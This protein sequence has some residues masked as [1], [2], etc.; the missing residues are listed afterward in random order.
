MITGIVVALPEELSTLTSADVDK[1]RCYPLS[2]NV[3]VAL[4]G[5]GPDNARKAAQHLLTQGATRLISWGCA[6]ALAPAAEPGD[7]TLPE[8]VLQEGAPTYACDAG[9]RNH[10]QS[11][12]Q[13]VVTIRTGALAGSADI[14]ANGADKLALHSR[15]DA[16]AL[17]MESHAVIS[18]SAE[19]GLPGLV[20]RAIADP[21][22]MNLPDAVTQ[23]LTPD[24]DVE[25]G[26]LLRHLLRHPGQ[27]PG[28]I[29]LGLHFKAAQKTLRS[30]AVNLDK[31]TEFSH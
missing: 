9:W 27:I 18:V 24:G 30:A 17:D 14:V 6:A 26:V 10:C 8:T 12:L 28:L 22:T 19:A 31:I 13:D 23:A 15:T 21:A 4:A 20:I 25:L 3:L 7:L 5:A 16:V 11:I 1:G 29:K 2:D